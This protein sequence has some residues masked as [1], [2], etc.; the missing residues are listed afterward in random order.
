MLVCIFKRGQGKGK[1]SSGC[2]VHPA[3]NSKHYAF[4]ILFDDFPACITIWTFLFSHLAEVPPRAEEE[5]SETPRFFSLSLDSM[6][7]GQIKFDARFDKLA[8]KF[9]EY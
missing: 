1:E 8:G 6:K 5:D 7:P 9:L 4:S 2:S 3:V